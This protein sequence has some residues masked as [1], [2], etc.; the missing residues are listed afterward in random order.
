ML[1]VFEIPLDGAIEPGVYQVRAGMYDYPD[2]QSV[3]VV[4]VT[5]R[6]VDDAVLLTQVMIMRDSVRD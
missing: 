3:P 6:P 4:D 1:A 5:G 2:V